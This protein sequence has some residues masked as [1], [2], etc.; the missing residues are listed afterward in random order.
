MDLARAGEPVDRTREPE[1]PSAARLVE[2]TRKRGRS[3][4]RRDIQRAAEWLVANPWALVAA[5]ALVIVV[6]ILLFGEL[7]ASDTQRRLR[8][9]PPPPRAQAPKPRPGSHPTPLLLSL[10]L[11]RGPRVR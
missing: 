9:E 4:M 7:S 3:P 5:V 2:G 8:A 10:P 11:P 6:P 1:V